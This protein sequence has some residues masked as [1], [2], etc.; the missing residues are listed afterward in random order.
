MA[1]CN[2]TNVI[3]LSGQVKK[4]RLSLAVDTGANVSILSDVAYNALKRLSRGGTW[5]L[6]PNDL[7]LAGVTG[8]SLHILGKVFLP[9]RI[10]RRAKPFKAAFYVATNL[11]SLLT[12]CLAWQ[13]C[14][15]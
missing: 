3:A 11:T 8:G 5:S 14:D 6:H 2:K 12:V 1:A 7:N 4:H 15:L 10:F 9:I 13:H